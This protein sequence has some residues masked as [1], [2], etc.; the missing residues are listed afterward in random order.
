MTTQWVDEWVDAWMS[1]WIN[2]LIR[3]LKGERWVGK[4]FYWTMYE[5]M[6]DWMRGL[7][8]EHIH[9]YPAF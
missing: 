9:K 4:G 7:L 1:E 8:N 2:V 6:K 5:C 3:E